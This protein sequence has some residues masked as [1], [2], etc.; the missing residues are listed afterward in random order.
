[1]H[2]DPHHTGETGEMDDAEPADRRPA[3]GRS[4]MAAVASSRP[5]GS[6]MGD[7][8][9]YDAPHLRS[10]ETSSPSTRL[11]HRVLAPYS[12]PSPKV[13]ETRHFEAYLT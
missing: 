4:S 1:M 2:D 10:A 9:V 5:E 7:D 8:L 11:V 3:R 6:A 13:G 12:S